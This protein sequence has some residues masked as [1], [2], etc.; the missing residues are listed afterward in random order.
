MRES[1]TRS[2]FSYACAGKSTSREEYS[3]DLIENCIEDI[4]GVQKAV[5]LKT[6]Q[7][8]VMLAFQVRIQ[9]ARKSR[10]S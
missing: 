3:G 1:Q 9:Q 5:Q 8:P 10:T 6:D 7:E 2:L 4:K